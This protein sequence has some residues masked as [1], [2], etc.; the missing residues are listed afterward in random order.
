MTRYRALPFAWEDDPDGRWF[1][2]LPA[3]PISRLSGAGPML[4]DVVVGAE[5]PL[6]AQDVAQT[7][8]GLLLGVPED[9][10]ETVEAFL[11]ELFRLGLLERVT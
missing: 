1:A 4:L 3:G 7:V 9:L 2:P 5:R 10:E 11:E 6:S 8:E